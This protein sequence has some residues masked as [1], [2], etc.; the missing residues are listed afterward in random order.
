MARFEKKPVEIEAV[1]FLDNTESIT[2]I[3]NMGMGTLRV[4]YTQ[5][6]PIIK[7]KTLEGTMTANVG[8]WI[9][10]GIRGE[11]YP[12]RHDIFMDTYLPVVE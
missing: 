10:K 3:S 4:D 11:F 9:I 5:A 6:P 8:D 1:R 12:C 7:I 2:E